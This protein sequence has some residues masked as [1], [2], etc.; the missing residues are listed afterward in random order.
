METFVDVIFG[1][2]LFFVGNLLYAWSRD[3][4]ILRNKPYKNIGDLSFIFR[5]TKTSKEGSSPHKRP[6]KPSAPTLTEN[7][8]YARVAQER[9]RIEQTQEHPQK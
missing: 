2:I 3:F 1:A 5:R 8:F 4:T 6:I 9:K 7:E